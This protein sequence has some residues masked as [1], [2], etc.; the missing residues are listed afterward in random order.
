MPPYGASG[1]VDM[2]L[3][4]VTLT[5]LMLGLWTTPANASQTGNQLYEQCTRERAAPTYW[6]DDAA[7]TAYIS[8][9]IEGATSFQEFW[10]AD[11]PKAICLPPNVTAGQMRDVVVA[12]LARNPER[13]HL[14]AMMSIV[15]AAVAAFPCR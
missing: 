12:Y 3:M 8:G 2:K 4:Q 7:C 14:S 15:T 13:R 6:Y 10:P 9:F 5:T 1:E 11:Q